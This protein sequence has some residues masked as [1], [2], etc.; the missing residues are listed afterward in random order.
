MWKLKVSQGGPDLVSVNNFIGREHW[1][2]DPNAGTPEEHAE[3]ERVREE[4]KKNRFKMKQSC[5]LLMRMQIRKENQLRPIPPPVKVQESEEITEEAVTTTL[6]RALSSISSLQAHDGHWPAEFGGPLVFVGPLV[7]ALSITGDLNCMF[8]SHHRKEIIRYLYNTQNEDGG[9]SFHIVGDSTMFGSA[10][11][12]IALRILGEGPEDGEDRAMARG[13]KWILDHGG[14]VAMPSWGKFWVSVLGAYEW[15]GCNPLPPEFWLLPNFSPLNPGKMLCYARLVYMPMSYLYGK[16]FVGPITELVKSLRQELYN[17]PYELVNWNKARNTIA[18][19]DL[20]FPHPLVQDLA[21]DFLQYIVEPFLSLWPF[22]MVRKK[23]VKIAIDHIR[24]EDE[25]SRYLCIGG[26][27]KVLCLMAQWVEDPYSEAYKRHLARL[28][29]YYWVAEDGLKLQSL[30]CQTWSAVFAIQAI[31]HCNLNEECAPTLRKAYDFMKASQVQENPPGDFKD[32]YRHITKGSWTLATQDYGWQVS[33]VT[34][35][36]LKATLMLSQLPADLVGEKM[37]TE[38]FYDAVNVVLSL[39]NGNGGFS[40]WEPVKASPWMQKFNPTE[41][42]EDCLFE[43]EYIECTSSAVEGL[44]L[45]RKLYPKHRRMEIDNSISK[46]IQYIQDIQ[47]PDG[48]WYGNWGICYTYGTW[49]AVGALTASGKNYQNCAAIRKA[50]EFL[51]SKQLPNGGW[52]ESYLSCHNKVWSNIKGNRE[53]VV[54]TA[55]AVLTLINA[56]QAERDP[57][58]IH[59]GVRILINSQLEDGE[60]PQQEITGIFF[61]FCGLNYAAFR[62]IFPLWALGEYRR[63]VLLA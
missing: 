2:F 5:D 45:F 34:A 15:S 22:S 50:C 11:S 21:W 19:E 37:E 26:V 29:D 12:Y 6:R 49:F 18:K 39:Q 33:D 53:N 25:A 40:A 55:W 24:Y 4:Y 32:M 42:Y 7:M 28:P 61:R 62:D 1:E 58:P 44:V 27:E 9:W 38:R 59:R 46:A 51:L 17:V 31:L 43:K 57:T 52:G 41:V 63:L 8:S 20:Y 13:R 36:G 23:A 47:E 14:L 48:S 54:Q 3:V 56:G 60:F 10:L 30:G 35:E 16:R